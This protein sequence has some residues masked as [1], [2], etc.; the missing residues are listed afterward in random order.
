[1]NIIKSGKR[2]VISQIFHKK[3][4]NEAIASWRLDLKRILDVFSVRFATSV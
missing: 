2:N 4:D 1:M 3:K